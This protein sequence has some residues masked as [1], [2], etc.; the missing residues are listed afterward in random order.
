MSEIVVT[1]NLTKKYSGFIALD[2]LNFKISKNTCVG[3][4]GPNGAGKSTTIKILTGLLRPSSG[5]AFI[6]G[7]DVTK[8]TRFALSGVGIVQENPQFF[9]KLTPEEILLYFGKLRGMEKNELV[10]R[11]DEVLDLVKML[12]WK[13][14]KIETFSKG[15]NQRFALASALLHDPMLIILDEPTIGLDPRGIIEII[16]IIKELKKQG[17]TIFMSSHI[18]S[19]VQEVCDKIALIDKGKLKIYDSVERIGYKKKTSKINVEIINSLTSKQTSLIQNFEG[20]KELKQES[21]SSFVVEFLGTN[22]ERAR[23]LDDIQKTGVKV[24][25]F[26]PL[27]SNLESLYMDTTS[28]ESSE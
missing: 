3:F 23:L 14:K 19:E 25:S 1:E 16:E 26:K 15:M 27:K 5:K 4:L 6:A 22:E 12:E 10:N 13:K 2:N 11:I 18:L 24:V 8:Q 9:P 28:T 7:K 17:K 21:K 20:V